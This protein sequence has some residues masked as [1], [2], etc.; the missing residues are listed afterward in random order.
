[1]RVLSIFSFTVYVLKLPWGKILTCNMLTN[2]M[3]DHSLGCVI[4]V[5]E[6]NVGIVAQFFCLNT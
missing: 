1:M 3:L 5:C 2:D 4:L 6:M